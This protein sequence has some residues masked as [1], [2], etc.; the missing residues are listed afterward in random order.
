M[1]KNL[2]AVAAAAGLA[3]AVAGHADAQR[4][5]RSGVGATGH[6]IASAHTGFTASSRMTAGRTRGALTARGRVRGPML[7]P[8]GWSHGRKVGWHCRV[9]AP[10]CIPPGLR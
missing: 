6:G 3:V 8:S 5:Q 1:W 10:G 9:G 7:R 4:A 2:L